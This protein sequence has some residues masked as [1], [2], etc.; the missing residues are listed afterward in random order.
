M[1]EEIYIW[2]NLVWKIINEDWI[3]TFLNITNW[4]KY[5]NLTDIEM[6]DDDYNIKDS[7]WNIIEWK[8]LIKLYNNSTENIYSFDEN[9]LLFK[10]EQNYISKIKKEYS[11]I[12]SWYKVLNIN[13]KYFLSNILWESISNTYDDIDLWNSIFSD[14]SSVT[15]DDKFNFI[16]AKW[17]ELSHIW[18]DDC[19]NFSVKEF[20]KVTR[21]EFINYLSKK[22]K[23][24]SNEWF[25]K[26]VYLNKDEWYAII[27]IDNKEVIVWDYRNF[28]YTC[29][30][31]ENKYFQDKIIY[32]DYK[33]DEEFISFFIY[34]SYYMGKYYEWP[35]W[36]MTDFKLWFTD[37]EKVLKILLFILK[38]YKSY[39]NKFTFFND[40]E[41]ENNYHSKLVWKR[42]ALLSS[43]IYYLIESNNNLKK[44]YDSSKYYNLCLTYMDSFFRD[45]IDLYMKSGYTESEALWAMYDVVYWEDIYLTYWEWEWTPFCTWWYLECL[46]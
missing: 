2:N 16:T 13:D 25:K 3:Y 42:E 9:K 43:A 18:F 1:E 33:N 20:S 37:T 32:D 44:N 29:L 22:W 27:I 40:K 26:L 34:L 28:Q 39:K 12:I 46:K 8:G 31:E 23:F 45:Y 6:F 7:E 21:W 5:Y 30:I 4:E 11:K 35:H 38:N 19:E 17:K 15:L 41:F 36:K 14:I 24:L 10:I